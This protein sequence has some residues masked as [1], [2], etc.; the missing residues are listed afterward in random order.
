MKRSLTSFLSLLLMLLWFPLLSGC[1]SDDKEEFVSTIQLDKSELAFDSG[2]DML[3]L[4]VTSNGEWSV[5]GTTDWCDLLP[6]S[7]DEGETT[8]SVAVTENTTEEDRTCTLTFRNGQATAQLTVIQYAPVITHYVDMGFD[9]TN[10]V[11]ITSFN[12]TTGELKVTY[13]NAS[14]LP[15]VEADDVILLPYEGDYESMIRIVNSVS[16]SGNV[17]TLQTE[18]GTM[19]NLF[20]NVEFALVTDPSLTLDEAAGAVT[21][22]G[23]PLRTVTPQQMSVTMNDGS[24]RVVYDRRAITRE[25]ILSQTQINFHEDYNDASLYEGDWGRIYWERC[26]FDFSLSS[27]F[28]F[29]FGDNHLSLDNLQAYQYYISGQANADLLLTYDWE[30]EASAVID[31]TLYRDVASVDLRFKVGIVPIN[32][33]IKMDLCSYLGVEAKAEVAAKTGA[34]FNYD[35]GRVGL[36]WKKGDAAPS[37]IEHFNTPEYGIYDPTF[38]FQSSFQFRGGFYPRFYV[39]FEKLLGPWLSILPCLQLDAEAGLQYTLS[40]DDQYMGWKADFGALLGYNYGMDWAFRSK[41]KEPWSPNKEMQF[42]D[43]TYQN[44]FT[45]P[46]SVELVSPKNGS[47][48]FIGVPTAVEFHATSYSSLTPDMNYDCPNAIIC[49]ESVSGGKLSNEFVRTNDEGIATVIWTPKNK[50]DKLIAKIVDK[51]GECIAS[52]TLVPAYNVSSTVLIQSSQ[53]D[54][55]YTFYF[56]VYY[57]DSSKNMGEP[58]ANLPVTFSMAGDGR[59]SDTSGTTDE[60]GCVSVTWIAFKKGSNVLLT[61]NMGNYG[62]TTVTVVNFPPITE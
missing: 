46:H 10:N 42:L 56:Y 19:S 40:G 13:A 48:L 22:S 49:F 16:T 11:S 54:N 17:V 12:E 3:T 8:V 62:S 45:A 55:T 37:V 41:D 30:A 57:S 47:E 1:G 26:S 52:E 58:I 36:S 51:E 32:V 20:E 23:K 18:A 53:G 27:L 24:R 33:N 59:L 61:I 31:T 38:N 28:Y 39:M 44:L 29:S 43:D 34:T 60:D 2:E 9:D 14:A 25:S 4:V 5:S 50:K 35:L 15:S 7:G 6:T 21:R